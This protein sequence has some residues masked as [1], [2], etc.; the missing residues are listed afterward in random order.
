MKDTNAGVHIMLDVMM[1]VVNVSWPVLMGLGVVAAI[2]LLNHQH[3]NHSANKA[4]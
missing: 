2:A 4:F 1:A 3:D